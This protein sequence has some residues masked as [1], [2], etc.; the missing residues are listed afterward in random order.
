MLSAWFSAGS[1]ASTIQ[2]VPAYT[3]HYDV[4]FQGNNLGQLKI[5]IRKNSKTVIVRGETFP[6]ALAQMLGEGKIIETMEYEYTQRGETLQLVRL[7][8]QKGIDPSSTKTLVIDRDSHILW[9]NSHPIELNIN[10]Q[11]DAYIFPLL[12]IL[13]L[14]EVNTGDQVKLVSAEKIRNYRYL[15]PVRE[16][17][18]NRAGSFDT[19]KQAR[20]RLNNS[21]TIAIWVTQTAPVMPVQIQVEHNNGHQIFISLISISE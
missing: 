7:T 16:T 10:D 17:I 21:N 5:S 2:A 13:G 1:L 20:S 15:K 3:L 6:S 19:L 12:S 4:A 9:A 11:V 18:H 14:S 8:E